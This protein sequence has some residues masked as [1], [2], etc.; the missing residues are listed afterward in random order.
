M[1]P[2]LVCKS[3]GVSHPEQSPLRKQDLRSTLHDILS[4]QTD[5]GLVKTAQIFKNC[6]TGERRAPPLE[7]TDNEGGP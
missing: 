4:P 7:A 1:R 2:G 5:G 6:S 3:Q